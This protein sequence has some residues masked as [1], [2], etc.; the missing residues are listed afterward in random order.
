[1]R[2]QSR[3]VSS[4]RHFITNPN[5][6]PKVDPSLKS[7]SKYEVNSDQKSPRPKPAILDA[8]ESNLVTM[9]P[10]RNILAKSLSKFARRQNFQDINFDCTKPVYERLKLK[11]AGEHFWKIGLRHYKE[12][13]KPQAFW[14]W[15]FFN[16]LVHLVFLSRSLFI[17]GTMTDDREVCKLK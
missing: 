9:F 12:T 1:M 17:L 14:R 2:R 7:N 6:N 16:L 4:V 3:K 15:Q 8:F 11:D 13:R 5:P 10:K